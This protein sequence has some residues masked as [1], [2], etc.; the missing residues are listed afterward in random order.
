MR[1][2]MALTIP[3]PLNLNSWVQTRHK[4]KMKTIFYKF[5]KAIPIYQGKVFNANLSLLLHEDG[6]QCT[7]D[8]LVEI[9]MSTKGDPRP[10]FIGAS[11]SLQE[12]VSYRQFLTKIWDYFT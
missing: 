7:I 1:A 12:C 2:L 4:E 3:L 8:E 11:L 5:P 10:T 6:G 9:S